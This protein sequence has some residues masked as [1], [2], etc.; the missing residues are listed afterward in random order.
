MASDKNKFALLRAIERFNNPATRES[1]FG[2]YAPN[3]VLHR[4]PSLPPGLESINSSIALT[5]LLS[6]I[7]Y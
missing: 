6:R 2:L 7:F 3:A 5:G 4:S 1:Y